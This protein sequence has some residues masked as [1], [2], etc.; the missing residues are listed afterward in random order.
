MPRRKA[1]EQVSGMP[2]GWHVGIH[3]RDE[4]RTVRGFQ[5][6][7]HFMGDNVVEALSGFFDKLRIEA[8]GAGGVVATAPLCFHLL[9]E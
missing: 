4:P 2:P 9:R 7:S 8:D 5:Q 1:I 6:V 3:Q